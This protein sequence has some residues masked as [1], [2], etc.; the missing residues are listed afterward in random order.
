M[1]FYFLILLL[2]IDHVAFGIGGVISPSVSGGVIGGI[3]PA[4][5]DPRKV[6]ST[7]DMESKFFEDS[8]GNEKNHTS[9]GGNAGISGSENKAEKTKK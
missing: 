5:A 8:K 2:F 3:G 6:E 7:S 4:N 9:I 1:K